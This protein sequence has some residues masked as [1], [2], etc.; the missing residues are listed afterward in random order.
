MEAILSQEQGK[1]VSEGSQDCQTFVMGT[2]ARGKRVT[3]NA[4]AS[5]SEGRIVG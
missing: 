5:A 1:F 4:G 3:P 2:D